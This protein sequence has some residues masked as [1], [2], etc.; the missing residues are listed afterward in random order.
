MRPI[1]VLLMLLAFPIGG[2]EIKASMDSGPYGHT[3]LLQL[4]Q[5]PPPEPEP[6]APEKPEP[7]TGTTGYTL[8]GGHQSTEARRQELLQKREALRR[9]LDAVERDLKRLEAQRAP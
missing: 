4:S 9:A 1:P 2:Y 5:S 6:P 8:R 7:L 3:D